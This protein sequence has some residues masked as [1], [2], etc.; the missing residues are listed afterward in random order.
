MSWFNGISGVAIVLDHPSL[1]LSGQAKVANLNEQLH[2]DG[3][4]TVDKAL[5]DLPKSSAPTLGDDVVIVRKDAKAPAMP[6][7]EKEKMAKTAEKPAGSMTPVMNIEVGFGS[8]FRFRGSGADLRLGGT[9][10]VHSE[11][12]LPLRASGTIH[13]IGAWA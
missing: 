10:M 9:M 6:L 5:F 3:K 11:P 7:T 1:L 12:F 4:F 13:V 2:L 8:D